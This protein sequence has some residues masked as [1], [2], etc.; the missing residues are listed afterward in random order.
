VAGPQ[1]TLAASGVAAGLGSSVQPVPSHRREKKQRWPSGCG[2]WWQWPR[3]PTATQLGLVRPARRDD[4]PEPAG[5]EQDTPASAAKRPAL[6][7]RVA[8]QVLPFQ[9]S[10]RL[11]ETVPS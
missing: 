8:R 10:A 1:D 11:R 4:R 2:G 9:A 7:G 6:G 3:H 5:R